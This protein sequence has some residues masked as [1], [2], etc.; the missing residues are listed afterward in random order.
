[1]NFLD[2]LSFLSL[3]TCLLLPIEA[4]LLTPEQL[5]Q[6]KLST[7]NSTSEVFLAIEPIFTQSLISLDLF[8]TAPYNRNQ[9]N[10]MKAPIGNTRKKNNS[11]SSYLVFQKKKNENKKIIVRGG[12]VVVG[13]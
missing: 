12:T 5:A 9:N 6:K 4:V 7:I 10:R 2:Y 13:L 8:Q 3:E 11:F 1:M